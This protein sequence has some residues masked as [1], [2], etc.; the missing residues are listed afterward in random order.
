MKFLLI[1]DNQIDILIHNKVLK[2]INQNY[3]IVSKYSASEALEHLKE[4]IHVNNFEQW[5]DCILL[6]LNMPL[7]DGFDFMAELSKIPGDIISNT[8][9]YVVTSSMNPKDKEKSFQY[10]NVKSF[11]EKPLRINYFK[12]VL[13][14]AS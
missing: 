13:D 9:I 3:K 4:M 7:M 5:P 11:I 8:T 6:D 10:K 12:S 2:R 14:N 1:D